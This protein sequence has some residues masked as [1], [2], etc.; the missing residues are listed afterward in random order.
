MS[1]ILLIEDNQ[2]NAD[3]MIHIL[4]TAGYQIK[5]FINGLEGAKQAREEHPALI[6][7]D[8]NLPDIDGRTLAFTL[9]KQLGANNAPPIIACTAR[10]GKSEARLAEQ[11]G[12]SAF[13]SKPFT[14]DELLGLVNRFFVKK[15]T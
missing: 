5:H 14:P 1:Y 6:L 10:T 15:Q 13:L 12:C 11:F 8:F 2:S 7:M 3:M 4:T 9:R